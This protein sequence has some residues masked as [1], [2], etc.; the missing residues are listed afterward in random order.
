MTLKVIGFGGIVA[1]S[2]L[3]A[4]SFEAQA[5]S[6]AFKSPS[7]N[8]ACGLSTSDEFGESDV[9][10]ICTI[11]EV[12]VES[13]GGCGNFGRRYFVMFASQSKTSMTCGGSQIRGSLPVL[14]YGRS[15]SNEGF[16]CLSEKTGVTCQNGEGN[17]FSLSKA[18]QRIF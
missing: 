10:L 15:W 16:T 3:L 1:I 2:W 18:V 17:G 5:G 7:G 4:S 13:F 12:T 6:P 8:I 14:Q 11:E 9:V